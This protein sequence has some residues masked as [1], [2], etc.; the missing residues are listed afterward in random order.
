MWYMCEQQY[1]PAADT[2]SRHCWS[3]HQYAQR[4]RL[5]VLSWI[6]C[7]YYWLLLRLL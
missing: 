2:N 7:E 3:C 1:T 4:L 6:F 5:P